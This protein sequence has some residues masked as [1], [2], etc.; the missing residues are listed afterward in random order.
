SAVDP[1]SGG[2]ASGIE[3]VDYYVDS[4]AFD[5]YSSAFGLSEGV[6]TV[7]Y[8]ARDNAGNIET[9]RA[10]EF[11]VDNTA[12]VSRWLVSSGANIELVGKFYLNAAGKIALE[13]A[14][15]VGNGVASGVE[16]IYYGVDAAPG[17]RYA[18][19]FGLAEGIRTIGFVAKDNVLN[20]EVLK[21]TVIYADGTAPVSELSVSGDQYRGQG[22]GASAGDGLYV[23]TRSLVMLA[24]AD[25]VIGGVA[26]GVRDT[27]YA[28]DGATFAAYSPFSLAS[29]GR[30]TVTFYSSDRVDN[31]EAAKTAGLLVDATPP[32]T[33]FSVAGARHDA[34]GVVYITKDSALL[35]SADDPVSNEVA[36][37]VLLTRYRIDGGAWTIYTGSFTIAAEGRHTL[38]YLSLDRVN[39][40]EAVRTVE[41]AVDNTPP[42]SSISLGEPKFTAF[43]LSVLTPATPV[44]LSAYDPLVGEVASGPRGIS[45]ELVPYGA[46]SG[47]RRDYL[48]PF[49]LPQGAWEVRFWSD[50]N[51][52]NTEP[53][54]SVVLAVST[55]QRD[56]LA[57]VAGLDAAGSSDIAGAV[58]SNA[59]VSVAGSARILGDVTA[60]AITLTGKKAQITGVR[61][62]ASGTLSP[63][64]IPLTLTENFV[65]AAA[66]EVNAGVPERYL[67]DG[68]LVVS[69]QAELILT[70][71][72]YRFAGIELAGGCEVKAGG[73]VNILVEGDILISGGSGLNAD[74]PASLMNLFLN[75]AS[76]VTF[77]GGG[78]VA[79]YLYAPYAHMGLTGNS[80]LGGHYFVGASSVSGNGNLVQAGESLPETAPAAGDKFK[81]SAFTTADASYGVLAGPDAA[82]RLGEVYVFP[83]PALRGAAPTFHF[84]CGIAD[85]VNIKIYTTSG[86]FAHE[87]TL[88]GM[89][90]ALD[91]GNGLSYAYE[92]AW[93]DHIPSGVY[94]YLIE[95]ARAG[96]KLKKTGKFA[97]VR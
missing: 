7:H 70:T 91:D 25:P 82:F 81:T 54:K 22:A 60:A 41:L 95:A 20:A 46:S 89:P 10:A 28:V 48:E 94:Y 35:L 84:E 13:S 77:T 64:P 71:G 37:G 11:L 58:R 40:A 9:A 44:T 24:A 67:V 19:P 96:Q 85:S 6:R 18:A 50:D 47:E 80:L 29:E 93:R 27:L 87:T 49:T 74:G 59:A 39:N 21:S 14:D 73:P 63:E 65:A 68:K 5:I 15:P 90:V 32:V 76:S 66:D 34:D 45:Y 51:V 30:R 78:K 17:L 12:P 61:T 31:V 43:G 56:A 4:G 52:G 23:S 62:E 53:L 79:A 83:N 92:Y 1:V 2:T 8:R 38:E 3:G 72:T 75:K 69:E 16:G 57:S 55:L 26:A 86:R 42:A 33:A 97:V 36:S 88:T